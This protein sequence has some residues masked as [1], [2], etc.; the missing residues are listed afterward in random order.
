MEFVGGSIIPDKSFSCIIYFGF[1][2]N[3]DYYFVDTNTLEVSPQARDEKDT[4]QPSLLIK[5]SIG[6]ETL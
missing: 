6:K 5:T 4:A 3:G 2:P 1:K